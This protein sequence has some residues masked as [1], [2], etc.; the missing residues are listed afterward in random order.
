VRLTNPTTY[1]LKDGNNENIE[2]G[3]YEEELQ[4]V[5]YPDVFLVEKVL[6]KKENKV[7]VKWLGFDKSHNSWILK[8]D[9]L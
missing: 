2:G 7:F 3:F 9:V 8:K 4:K 6:R 1:I 5:K